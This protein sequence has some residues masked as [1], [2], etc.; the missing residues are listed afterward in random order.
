MEDRKALFSKIISISKT[1]LSNG[2][3]SFFDTGT[4]PLSILNAYEQD[5]CFRRVQLMFSPSGAVSFEI[6]FRYKI[7]PLIENAQSPHPSVKPDFLVSTALETFYRHHD[8][9]QK[10]NVMKSLAN[11]TLEKE[12]NKEANFSEDY[13]QITPLIPPDPDE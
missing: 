13:S 3:Y 2:D 12:A 4:V 11:D 1:T 6:K 9:F 8:Q 5:A 10:A 7:P